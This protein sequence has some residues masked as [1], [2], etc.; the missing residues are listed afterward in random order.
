MNPRLVAAS[1]GA[2]M[3]VLGLCMTAALPWAVYYEDGALGSF[4]IVIF[5]CVI[6]G[7]ITYGLFNDKEAEYGLREGFAIVSL[8]WIL[9][10]F[11]G[12]LPYWISGA[13]P[14]FADALFESVSGFTTTG[15]SILSD[16]ETLPHSLLF[17]RSLTH[18][19]GG[20]GI[21][22]LSVAIL[23]L[24][25]VGGMAM[26]K[27]EVPSPV[28]D[29]L[30]PT[31]TATAKTLWKVYLLLTVIEALL[32]WL[33][34]MPLFD[35]LC[36]TF[37]TLATGGFSTKNLSIGYYDGVLIKTIIIFFMMVAGLN[38][39]LHYQALTGNPRAYLRSFE[40]RLYLVLF[41]VTSVFITLSVYGTNFDSIG[42]ALLESSFQ[43]ASIMTTTGYGT[44]DWE[45]WP[46]ACQ[47]I[48]LTLMFMGGCAGSTGGG[49]KCMRLIV[50]AKHAFRELSL[51]IHPR[52]V[53]PLKID[54]NVIGTPIIN[55]ILAF[56]GLFI[57]VWCVSTSLL[58]VMGIDLITAI[59]ASTATLSNIG[60]GLN[61]VGPTD[62]YG[63]LSASAKS[64][65]IFNMIAG[66]LE[67]YTVFVLFVPGFWRK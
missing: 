50:V 67:L 4:I 11:V 8:G 56:V 66:R 37:G 40:C 25:G 27:A 39:T 46:W 43:T 3:A 42:K 5:F 65:L 19:L 58:V 63:W 23:P 35:S 49:M 59:G 47:W 41:V 14:G 18:W 1:L 6:V 28:L 31:V 7:R 20:M 57:G 29:K 17:W 54:K 12:A 61:M 9:A 32:L 13:V 48:L 10:G 2:L 30:K 51:L 24:L 44:V 52:A 16:I 55:S 45:Q 38:F 36:H 64:L 33:A 60:P 62:N 53:I 22:V 26:L 21:I 34:G 15:A